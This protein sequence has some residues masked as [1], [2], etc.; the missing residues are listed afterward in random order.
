MQQFERA[1][2]TIEQYVEDQHYGKFILKPLERGFGTTIGNAIRRVLLAAMPGGA[3]YSIRIDGVHHEF[4]AIPGVVE[5]V[6]AIILNIKTM[7]LDVEDDESHTLR[8]DVVGPKTVTAGDIVYP[9]GVRCLN[10][11][12]VLCTVAEGGKLEMELKARQGRGYVSAD[13]NKAMYNTSSTPIGTIFTD[14]VFT[15]VKKAA[16]QVEPTR[17]GQ[18]A[19]YDALT[20]EVW[21]NEVIEP[22]EA[23]ALASKILADHLTLL[24]SV[25]PS[26]SENGSVIK[27]FSSED[28]SKGSNMPIEE[29]D[30]SVRSY[31]CLKRAGIQTV[32]ELTQKSEEEMLRIR[33]LGK[34]SFKEVKD[35]LTTID[36]GF[37]TND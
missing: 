9:T 25:K 17:V 10:P 27:E 1:E 33:N 22:Q 11:D 19:K 31:N 14:S 37:R 36:K 29:L 20:L 18:S 4:T 23:I 7:I 34:K 16:F 8:L 5:D 15:P 2:F 26:V 24:E 35:K 12:L 30:L 6:T 3:V 28:T 32:D 13:E 21:T